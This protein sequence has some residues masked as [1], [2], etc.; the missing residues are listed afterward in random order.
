MG[1]TY[2]SGDSDVIFHT[3]SMPAVFL[4]LCGEVFVVVTSLF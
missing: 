1:K 4:P 2:T 3:A